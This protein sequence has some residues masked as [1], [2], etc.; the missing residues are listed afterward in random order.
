MRIVPN[1][2]HSSVRSHSGDSPNALDGLTRR[3]SL[4]VT[5]DNHRYP[6]HP[7]VVAS[8]FSSGHQFDAPTRWFLFPLVVAILVIVVIIVVLVAVVVAVVV[9]VTRS[10]GNFPIV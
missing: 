4:A 2:S 6:C 1:Q 8:T 5:T 9:V 7:P 3:L 10:H